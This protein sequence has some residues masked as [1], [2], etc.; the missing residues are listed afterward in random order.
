VRVEAVA[1]VLLVRRVRVA[2]EVAVLVAQML[3]RRVRLTQAVEVVVEALVVAQ[4][5]AVLAALA[6]SLSKYLTT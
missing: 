6:L 2:L 1:V 3:E 5:T 4:E